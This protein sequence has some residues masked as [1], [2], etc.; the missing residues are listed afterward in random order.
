M[1]A[2]SIRAARLRDNIVALSAL[3]A[4]NY[5]VPLVTVPYLVRVLGPSNFGA[6]SFAQALVFYFDLLT[7]YG[8]DLSATRAVARLR[9]DN[10][11]LAHTFWRT[12]YAKTALLLLSAAALCVLASFAPRL[13]AEPA[14]YVAAFLT[15]AGSVTFPVWLFQGLERMKWIAAA[16]ASA[17]LLT[18][19]ALMLLVNQPQEY[20]RAAAIQGAVPLLASALIL[21]AVWRTIR[22]GPPLPRLAGIRDALREGWHVFVAQSG[23]AI[24]VSTTTVVLGLVAGNAAVGF[25][26]AADKVIRAVTSML[27]PVAQALYPHLNNLK[28][29]APAEA[30]RLMRKS[31]AWIATGALAASLA[32]FAL[33]EPA[34][35]L[36]WGSD[37]RNSVAVLRCL[38]PL[39]FLYALI[40]ILGAQT[41][42]V[43]ERDA[44]LSRTVVCGSL[45]NPLLTAVGAGNLGAVGAA[46][47]AVTTAALT[48]TALAIQCRAAL[49]RVL[50]KVPCL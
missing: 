38:S 6:L 28:T 35:T 11:E 23:L 12:M 30:L 13:R 36:L 26:S 46:C 45:V 17:R 24:N 22:C 29:D 32:T 43:F 18:V 37:F 10:R 16:H 34:G 25:Y 3:Q 8:F 4:L 15:V 2:T 14:L 41:M 20:V 39:P 21:P 27:G 44:P 40:N 5:A 49:S 1:N 31:F 42:L 47:A 50:G 48:A 33:A 19:P 7:N 9:G